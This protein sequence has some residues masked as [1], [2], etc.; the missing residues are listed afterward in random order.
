MKIVNYDLHMSYPEIYEFM[1]YMLRYEPEV[2]LYSRLFNGNIYV[3]FWT[4]EYYQKYLEQ[5]YAQEREPWQ[6]APKELPKDRRDIEINHREGFY[7]SERGTTIVLGTFGL[8]KYLENHEI[9]PRAKPAIIVDL[10]R[11][12]REEALE[13]FKSKYHQWSFFKLREYAEDHKAEKDDFGWTEKA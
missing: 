9:S 6:R 1:K 12:P 5:W 4:P 11:E 3:S 2:V 8:L 10:Y 7:Y 13:A